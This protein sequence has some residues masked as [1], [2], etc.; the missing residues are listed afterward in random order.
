MNLPAGAPEAIG[1][2]GH[3]WPRW[4]PLGIVL[5]C[6]VTYNACPICASTAEP[7]RLIDEYGFSRCTQC[8]YVF[9]N[10]RPERETIAQY[11]RDFGGV[12]ESPV[13]LEEELERERVCPNSTLDA[14]RM[15]AVAQQVG[16]GRRGY[17]L[18]VGCGFG[19]FAKEATNAG[20]DVDAL[21]I[22]PDERASAERLLGRAPLNVTFEEFGENGK[23]YSLIIVSQVLEHVVD[24]NEWVAKMHR[25]LAPGGVVAIAVPNFGGAI[26]RVLATRDPYIT[27]PWHLNYFAPRNLELL[28]ESHDLV[29]RRTDTVSRLTPG[30][31]QRRTEALPRAVQS[32]VRSAG[33]AVEATVLR[34][35]DAR[36][37][38]MFINVYAQ[39]AG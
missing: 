26:R 34:A 15:I 4:Y 17:A 32:V 20:F 38:G 13:T 39:R 23:R 7:W 8:R 36:R 5:H 18:D 29:V 11:Y 24:V 19:F 3:G 6:A 25:L 30:A 16:G 35:L 1:R 10:P 12:V 28:L 9:V 2:I 22:A 37:T 31:I 27:P 14:A 21:E 33:G